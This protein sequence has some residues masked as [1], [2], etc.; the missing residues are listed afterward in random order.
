MVAPQQVGPPRGA[1]SMTGFN[2]ILSRPL[3]ALLNA[4]SHDICWLSYFL[5][6]V[7]FGPLSYKLLYLYLSTGEETQLHG[8]K[9]IHALQKLLRNASW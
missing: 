2:A 5:S 3:Q 1:D 4:D 9:R 8:G 7:F 6:A